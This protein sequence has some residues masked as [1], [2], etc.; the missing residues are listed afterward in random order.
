M[1]S[2]LTNDPP[3]GGGSDNPPS[4]QLPNHNNNNMYRCQ[5]AGCDKSYSTQPGLNNHLK[6]HF[7]DEEKPFICSHPGCTK[8]Y[9]Q[10]KGVDYHFKFAHQDKTTWFRCPTL[11]CDTSFF[12]ERQLKF[13]QESHGIFRCTANRCVYQCNSKAELLEHRARNHEKAQLYAEH[14]GRIRTSVARRKKN[15]HS[16]KLS[17]QSPDTQDTSSNGKEYEEYDGDGEIDEEKYN[18][19]VAEEFPERP[20]TNRGWKCPKPS[21]KVYRKIKFDLIQHWKDKHGELAEPDYFQYIHGPRSSF[22]PQQ[23]ANSMTNVSRLGGQRTTPSDSARQSAQIKEEETSPQNPAL[24]STALQRPTA[25]HQRERDGRNAGNMTGNFKHSNAPKATAS[26]STASHRLSTAADSQNRTAHP[27]SYYDPPIARP[28]TVASASSSGNLSI[29]PT[30]RSVNSTRTDTAVTA[31]DPARPVN[32]TRT[33]TADPVARTHPVN[34]TR[35]ETAVSAVSRARPVNTTRTETAVP[36]IARP[37]NS[38]RT[39]AADPA[40]ARSR[41]VNTTRTE[42]ADTAVA[43]ARPVNTT[44]PEVAIPAINRP[45]HRRPNG[46]PPTFSRAMEARRFS[47]PPARSIRAASPLDYLGNINRASNHR[48]SSTNLDRAFEP[49]VSSTSHHRIGNSLVSS[50]NHHRTGR[51]HIASTDHYRTDI[52]LFP[53]TNLNRSTNPRT[54]SLNAH[55]STTARLRNPPTSSFHRSRPSQALRSS[56]EEQG[57]EETGLFVS[58]SNPPSRPLGVRGFANMPL[59]RD[60]DSDEEDLR[61]SHVLKQDRERRATAAAA[62]GAAAPVAQI[63]RPRGARDAYGRLYSERGAGTDTADRYGAA[64]STDKDGKGDKDKKGEK[65]G[66]K[67]KSKPMARRGRADDSDD[68]FDDFDE[69]ELSSSDD[70]YEDPRQGL[71]QRSTHQTKR[72]RSIFNPHQSSSGIRNPVPPP[73]TPSPNGIYRPYHPYAPDLDSPPPSYLIKSPG[74]IDRRLPYVDRPEDKFMSEVAVTQPQDLFNA[75]DVHYYFRGPTEHEKAL[76]RR[77]DAEKEA[78]KANAYGSGFQ[79]PMHYDAHPYTA[80]INTRDR[81]AWREERLRLDELERRG[82]GFEEIERIRGMDRNMSGAP[83]AEAEAPSKK[84]KKATCAGPD[85]VK[86]KYN[87]RDP[88]KKNKRRREQGTGGAAQV[89]GTDEQ[90]LKGLG[91]PVQASAETS[92]DDSMMDGDTSN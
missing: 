25:Q 3:L 75:D 72:T 87:W 63:E 69:S 47:P 13:H 6:T 29:P 41:P 79:V 92:D 49:R 66:G 17:A 70:S 30:R 22:T 15:S 31:I 4:P 48:V 28:D 16:A 90:N 53:S 58:P 33:E 81:P 34:T 2:S 78:M 40:M 86:R 57:Q 85:R 77:L 50:D 19:E 74:V 76:Q 65:S 38:A 82:D 80:P 59:P 35:T 32:P 84:A 9:A 56:A 67:S 83:D 43:R 14:V 62:T 39:E 88:S 18:P 24:Y 7:T 46:P 68:D 12:G 64:G 8:R 26:T 60:Q 55:Q 89:D 10:K 51:S 61:P 5:H 45:V 36:A 54:F 11:G 71:G 27:R 23:T 52:P 73:R 44:R 20:I 91:P 42:T 21:C 37:V 1:S